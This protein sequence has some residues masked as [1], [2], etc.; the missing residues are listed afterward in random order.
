MYAPILNYAFFRGSVTRGTFPCRTTIGHPEQDLP[1]PMGIGRGSVADSGS[2][3]VNDRSSCF[4]PLNDSERSIAPAGQWSS[5]Y[6][7]SGGGYHLQI[8]NSYGAVNE[9][10]VRENLIFNAPRSDRTPS[11]AQPLLTTTTG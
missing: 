7:P 2:L 1:I 6:A 4:L 8:T 9:V 5:P 10:R 3:S 11:F